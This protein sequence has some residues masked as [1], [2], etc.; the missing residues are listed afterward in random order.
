MSRSKVG[1]LL[2]FLVVILLVGGVI[3]YVL[4]RVPPTARLL[5]FVPDSLPKAALKV[6]WKLSNGESSVGSSSAESTPSLAASSK[7]AA[8][9]TGTNGPVTEQTLN[10]IATPFALSLYFTQPEQVLEWIDNTAAGREFVTSPLTRGV[11]A[12]LVRTAGVRAEDLKIS[13]YQGVFVATF[14][15][16]MVRAHGAL[17]FDRMLGKRG[18][19]VTFHLKESPLLRAALPLALGTTAKRTYQ[20][21]GTTIVEAVIGEQRL[22]FAER[23]EVSYIGSDLRCVANA[24]EKDLDAPDVSSSAASPAQLA[25]RLRAEAWL[26]NLL[27][28]VAG[29]TNWN[30]DIGFGLEAKGAYPLY[31]NTSPATAFRFLKHELA[32]G[33]LAAVPQ[34]SVAAFAAS[35]AVPPD[36]SNEE[37]NTLAES[38]LAALPASS[39]SEKGGFAIVWDL[40]AQTAGLSEIGLALYGKDW[41]EEKMRRYFSSRAAYAHCASGDIWLAATSE[42]LL[43]RM[44]D[45]CEGNSRNLLSVATPPQG[46]ELLVSL[47]PSLLLRELV[48]AGVGESAKLSDSDPDWKKAY[49]QAVVH[50]EQQADTAFERIP[51]FL[52]AGSAG[53]Q[54]ARLSQLQ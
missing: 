26:E 19:I 7:S 1:R 4:V 21:D 3:G 33:V 27:P 45:A 52:L 38:G 29:T 51:R 46:T 5:A 48:R 23:G 53:E 41:S 8:V 9:A 28:L 10:V 37:W 32:S 16:E 39:P 40:Q 50:A 36:R 11:F 43:T 24:L 44:R 12:G 47:Q 17:H 42:S 54:G 18:A 6:N 35:F 2:L 30:M 34:N 14:M 15:R 22:Y 31:L 13:G 25:L 49:V 20:F